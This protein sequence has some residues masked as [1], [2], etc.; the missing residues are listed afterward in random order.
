MSIQL[1]A[2]EG[3]YDHAECLEATYIQGGK[4]FLFCLRASRAVSKNLEKGLRIDDLQSAGG[5]SSWALHAKDVI[6]HFVLFVPPFGEEVNLCRRFHSL[7]RAQ[8]AKAN[9]ICIIPD[10]FGTGDS[11][12]LLQE[13]DWAIWLHDLRSVIEHFC[14]SKKGEEY[15]RSKLSIVAV[16]SG[17]LLAADLMSNMSQNAGEPTLQNVVFVQ[18]EYSGKDIVNRLFRARI[19][20]QRLAGDSAENTQDL[21]K[22]VQNGKDVHAAGHTLSSS[23]CLSL[24]EK[25]LEDLLYES[26]GKRRTLFNLYSPV[27]VG[28]NKTQQGTPL[29]AFP[30]WDVK[31]LPSAPFWQLH[32]VEPDIS[33]IRSVS[34][35]LLQGI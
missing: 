8:I 27:S 7:I 29:I 24:C 22:L 31:H 10:L 30:A 20:T 28:P 26:T 35:A 32:D 11:A 9:A 21:W 18:P 33:L 12:G 4:G 1:S 15:V 2:T 3:E 13:A 17:C 6:H 5:G 34:S 23:L 14:C 16:R 19:M 25:T